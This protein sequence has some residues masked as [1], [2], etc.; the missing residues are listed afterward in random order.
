MFLKVQNIKKNS[1]L[2]DTT[3]TAVRVTRQ[4]LPMRGDQDPTHDYRRSTYGNASNVHRSIESFC[5]GPVGG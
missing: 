4:L 1:R 2:H 3:R 5:R